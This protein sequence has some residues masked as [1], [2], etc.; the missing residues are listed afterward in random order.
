MSLSNSEGQE[1]NANDEH[2]RDEDS[3]EYF[4]DRL[5]EC[6]EPARRLDVELIGTASS[7]AVGLERPRKPAHSV[8]EART[9]ISLVLML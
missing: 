3:G 2:N 6:G 4:V 1:N 8:H 5:T 7:L 9:R